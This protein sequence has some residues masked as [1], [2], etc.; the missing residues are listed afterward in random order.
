MRLCVGLSVPTQQVGLLT[1][2]LQ[3][4]IYS[5]THARPLHTSHNTYPSFPLNPVRSPP[6]SLSFLTF[7]TFSLLP[8]PGPF[9]LATPHFTSQQYSSTLFHSQTTLLV[10]LPPHN[11]VLPFT[12]AFLS[13]ARRPDSTHPHYS[14]FH[15]HLYVIDLHRDC[16]HISHVFSVIRCV[17]ACTHSTIRMRICLCQI[18]SYREENN[19]SRP[20]SEFKLRR[21]LPVL[22]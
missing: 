7:L 17:C 4:Q 3:P 8:Q 1:R 15:T 19:G 5:R 13:S 2:Y 10:S 22:C 14:F 6:S 20:I 12:I 11:H 18:R 21:A 9:K 16:E